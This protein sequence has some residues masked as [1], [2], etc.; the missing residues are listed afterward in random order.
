[1]IRLLILDVEG[2]VVL[3][4]GSQQPWPLEE[5]LEVR[6]SLA[7]SPLACVLCTGRQ[8][9][10]GEAV[11]QC[12][13]LFAPL[14]EAVRSGVRTR[15]GLDLLAW[16]SVLEHGACLYDPLAKRP[17]PHPALT[18][19][20]IEALQQLRAERLLPLARETGAQF[21]VGK[22]FCVSLNP[23]PVRPG[24]SERRPIGEFR[25]QVDQAVRGYEALV[26]VSHSASAVDLTPRGVS[27][28]SAVRLLLE[29]TGLAP[30]EVA[31]VGDTAADAAWLQE[32]GWR[33]APANGREALPGLDYYAEAE[34]ASGLLQ[35]LERLRACGYV[36]L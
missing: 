26:E 27:K 23:P 28:A 31:G 30:E 11:I 21:E 14:P 19:D 2:V 4:G 3:P 12:L 17:S 5:L 24:S 1:M 9:P 18:P 36:G 32:V 35:I 8:S 16:P 13:D 33:A 22:D 15:S 29:W 10:Y 34:V 20:R 7:A 25:L 6:R